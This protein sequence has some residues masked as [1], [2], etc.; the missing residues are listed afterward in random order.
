MLKTNGIIPLGSTVQGRWPTFIYFEDLMIRT[1][2]DFYLDLMVGKAKYTDEPARKV[3]ALWKEMIDKGYFSDP[4]TDIFAD[5]PRLMAQGKAGM[6]LIGNWY[7][8]QLTQMGLKVGEDVGAFILP[9]VDP[10]VGNV[11]IYEAAPM[12]VGRNA[13]NKENALKIADWWLSADT[14]YA[15]CKLT[16]F[17]PPNKK[18][19]TEFLSIP[20]QNI[21][22][23]VVQGN[24]RLINLL[25]RF[26]KKRSTSLPSSS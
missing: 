6:I 3:F 10:K 18:S 17:V 26:V 21:V 24:Y 15:W 4:G 12:L 16:G 19:P 13:P 23:Q 8:A 14:Q 20:M 1:N 9:P 5:Y 2:P 11:I 25:P 22:K 7:E